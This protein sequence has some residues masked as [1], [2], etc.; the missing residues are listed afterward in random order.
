MNLTD[1]QSA[2]EA[3]DDQIVRHAYEAADLKAAIGSRAKQIAADKISD[4][5]QWPKLAGIFPPDKEIDCSGVRMSQLEW[6]LYL[7][8]HADL[9]ADELKRC[10]RLLRDKMIEQIAT[11]EQVLA[12]ALGDTIGD[13]EDRYYVGDPFG[14]ES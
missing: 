1:L 3:R 7:A 8:R 2:V 13:L 14:N 6:L 11:D 12:R 9:P 4:L 5:S 10:V